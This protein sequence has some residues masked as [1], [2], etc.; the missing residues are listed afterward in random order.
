M[1]KKTIILM[2]T[3]ISYFTIYGEE[4]DSKIS[5]TPAIGVSGIYFN[6]DLNIKYIGH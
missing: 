1:N 5:D 2:L 6:I 3:V 4:L